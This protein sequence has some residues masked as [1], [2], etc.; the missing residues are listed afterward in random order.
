MKE[1]ENGCDVGHMLVQ[2]PTPTLC[3]ERKGSWVGGGGRVTA[4]RG[5]S[6]RMSE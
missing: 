3:R 2:R 5:I 4:G 6:S 1:S